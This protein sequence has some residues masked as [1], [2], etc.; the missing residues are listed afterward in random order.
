[1]RRTGGHILR[2]GALL[3]AASAAASFAATSA[4]RHAQQPD[5]TAETRPASGAAARARYSINLNLDFD[6]HAYAGTE[7]VR[8]TNRDTRPA[9]AIYFHL[10]PNLRPA[11]GAPSTP[12]NDADEPRLVVTGVRASADE[13]ATSDDA[14]PLSFTVE[15]G[16]VTLRVQLRTP[17]A[18]GE[19]AE[20]EI[21]FRGSIPEIDPDETSLTAHVVQQVGA[22]LRDTRETRR[23]RDTNFHSR[24]VTLLGGFHPVLAAREGGEWRRKVEPGVGDTVFA[25]AADY[26][27]SISAPADVALFTSGGEVSNAETSRSSVRGF[28]GAALRSFAVVA[29][30]TLRSAEAEAG[31][32]RVRSVYTAEHERVGR[33]ALAV[34]ADAART[35]QTRFGPLDSSLI[36]VTEAPLVAGLGSTEFTGLAVIAS[37][38]YVDFD[39]PSVRNLPEVVRE[40]RSSVEESLEFAVAQGV[41]HQWWGGAVGS[42]PAR[43]P[44]LDEALAHWSALLYIEDVHGEESARVALEDQLRGVYQLYRTFGGEDRAASAPSREYRNTFQ[45]AAIV[46]SKGALMFAA[47]RRQMGD[48]SFFKALRAYYEANRFEVAEMDDLRAAFAAE[49]PTGARRALLR[50]FTRWLSERHGDEDIA[51]PNAQLA[52]L[53]GLPPNGPQPQQPGRDGNA[54]SRLGKFFWRQMT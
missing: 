40:Q 15:D 17:V 20:V 53:L 24:G 46:V 1:M 22:A 33:R 28:R 37:A 21:E 39:S 8:W 5:A 11:G 32:V 36:T 6:A 25:D 44:V 14:R 35:Y 10:Y 7:R 50:T 18:A 30:R 41:A 48:E 54:F 3:L 13:A 29:G 42:D 45:Y 27:V 2:V 43:E 9:S 47:L 38:F 31:R 23:A 12:A 16:G 19:S 49:T 52:A 51:P 4:R 26:E 34:A